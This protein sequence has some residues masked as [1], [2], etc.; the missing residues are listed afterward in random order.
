MNVLILFV[1]LVLSLFICLFVERAGEM[2]RD[3]TCLCS[4]ADTAAAAAAVAEAAASTTTT[5]STLASTTAA[6]VM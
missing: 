4:M 1:S 6:G 2:K 5:M 3:N